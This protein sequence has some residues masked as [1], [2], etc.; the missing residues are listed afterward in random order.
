MKFLADRNQILIPEPHLRRPCP[1]S[2]PDSHADALTQC[3]ATYRVL[4]DT[5]DIRAR[6]ETVMEFD[7]TVLHVAEVARQLGLSRR[8]LVDTLRF[9]EIGRQQ[10][11]FNQH[12]DLT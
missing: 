2:N 9:F 11:P 5:L 4:E 3:R 8:T 7:K 1:E 12:R 6:V 10:R